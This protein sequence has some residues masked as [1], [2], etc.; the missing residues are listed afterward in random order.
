MR[1]GI[2]GR[3]AAALAGLAIALT[4][5]LPTAIAT[6]GEIT[7]YA[8]DADDL[9]QQGKPAEALGA[10]DKATDAFWAASPLQVRLALFA[11]SVEGYGQ[12]TPVTTAAFKSGDSVTV[13]LEPVGYGYTLGDSAVTVA[14]T[15]GLEIRTPGGLVLAKTDDFGKLEWHG[16]TKSREVHAAV[17]VTLPELKPGDYQLVLTLGD[18][19]SGKSTA[20]T[21]PFSIVE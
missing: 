1:T 10:F 14:F 16:R 7:E 11:T 5:M 15:T 3:H 19:A 17:K 8:T 9:L 4:V 21:L 20:V 12:Y 13:Y 18:A 6:A 2:C